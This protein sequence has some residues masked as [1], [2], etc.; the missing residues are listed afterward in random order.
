M[1]I[2]EDVIVWSKDVLLP[3][4]PIGLFI[5]AFSESAFFPVPPDVILVPLVLASPELYIVYAAIATLASTLGSLLGYYIG[6][7][8][9]RPILTRVVGVERASSV[10]SYYNRWGVWALLIS[11]FT[12]IPYKAFTIASG[13][14][15]LNMKAFL[16]AA[17]L[18]RGFR[19]FVEAY[20]A[21]RFREEILGVPDWA[22]AV[23]V[24]TLAVIL[25]VYAVYRRLIRA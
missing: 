15:R 12:P 4:G 17:T 13:I 18:G 11:G 10:E 7:K 20:V 6:L 14:F 3:L 9:G 23:G 16:V 2:V 22:I 8:A 1:G 24:A 19:F 21:Y 25:G 5:V